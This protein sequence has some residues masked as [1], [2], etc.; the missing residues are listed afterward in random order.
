MTVC[1]D[2]AGFDARAAAEGG[3]G[4]IGMHERVELVGGR[5]EIDSAPGARHHGA[6]RGSGP[7]TRDGVALA[8]GQRHRAAE[9]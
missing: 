1:D 7:G 5:L 3:F 2:G 9:A 4:L 8:A 6:E